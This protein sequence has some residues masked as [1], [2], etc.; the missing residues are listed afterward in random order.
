M[1]VYH[2]GYSLEETRPNNIRNSSHG[3]GFYVSV[4]KDYVNQYHSG[5][6]F[7]YDLQ[8]GIFLDENESIPDDIF[9]KLDAELGIVDYE[10]SRMNS[11]I[12][13]LIFTSTELKKDKNMTF[14][15]ARLYV[16]EILSKYADGIKYLSDNVECY[17][18][19]N[20][21]LLQDEKEIIINSSFLKSSYKD[22]NWQDIRKYIRKLGDDPYVTQ[23]VECEN[24]QQL[25][26]YLNDYL[27]PI[28]VLIYDI[29]GVTPDD[30]KPG[31]TSYVRFG[32]FCSDG[33]I[34]VEIHANAL[35]QLNYDDSY[36]DEDGE[37][38]DADEVMRIFIKQLSHVIVHEKTHEYQYNKHWNREHSND[39]YES[40]SNYGLDYLMNKDEISAHIIGGLIE[41]LDKG[42]TKE[43]LLEAFKNDEIMD[44]MYGTSQLRDYNL[45]MR[46][47][48][49]K[50]FWKELYQIIDNLPEEDDAEPFYNDI[51]KLLGGR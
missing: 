37:D 49:M 41:L 16:S 14:P 17:C 20:K 39:A 19:F 50:R 26:D 4:S 5:K 33:A 48:G 32:G 47:K 10:K 36:C 15:K 22:F 13:K 43:D 35:A 18:I 30:G 29:G 6:L 25:L 40:M 23:L 45:T 38:I 51:S 27:D 34:R 9:R 31:V 24:P 2:K 42:Y 46:V 7:S 44:L 21:Q 1:L 12:D 28:D 8:Q 11:L 3:V